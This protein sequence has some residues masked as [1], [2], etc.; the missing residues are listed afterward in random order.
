MN[1]PSQ[2]LPFPLGSFADLGVQHLGPCDAPLV[3]GDFFNGKARPCPWSGSSSPPQHLLN[4]HDLGAPD[5]LSTVTK[6]AMLM[7]HTHHISSYHHDS[8]IHFHLLF[9]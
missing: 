7:I 6:E 4:A 1:Q 8:Y 3:V 2:F 9:P 5:N